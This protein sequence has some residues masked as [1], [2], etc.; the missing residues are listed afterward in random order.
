MAD[1]GGEY[2]RAATSTGM[3]SGGSARIDPF[4][5]PTTHLAERGSWGGMCWV[6]DGEA[7]LGTGRLHCDGSEHPS[8]TLTILS[9]LVSPC[10]RT[11]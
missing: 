7:V 3:G 10:Q 4:L 1:W 9:S 6:R 5:V 11:Q 2:C 8:V